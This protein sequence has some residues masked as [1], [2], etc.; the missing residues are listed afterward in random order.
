[1][2]NLSFD[3]WYFILAFPIFLLWVIAIL[4]F[5]RIS[6]RHID[7]EIVKNKGE[8]PEWD[9]GIGIRLSMYSRIITRKKINKMTLFDEQAVLDHAR[10]IDWYLA[11]FLHLTSIA[12]FALA[13]ITFFFFKDKFQD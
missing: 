6:M 3:V 2:F 9:K 13:F 12:F 10:K 7:S 1:M 4:A 8:A 5:G 11:W